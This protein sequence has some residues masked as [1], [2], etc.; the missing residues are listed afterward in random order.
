MGTDKPGFR[1]GFGSV[2][3]AAGFLFRAHRLWPISLVPGAI[4]FALVTAFALL[5][6]LLLRPA[7]TTWLNPEGGPYAALGAGLAGWLVAILAGALGALLALAITPP[8]SAP[9]LEHIVSARERS[10]GVPDRQ[11]IG[12]FAEMAFGLK[13]QLFAAGFA[14]PTLA[15]LWAIDLLFPPAAIVTVPL[16]LVV[17][18]AALSWNLLDY[19][20]TLRGVR[21]RDRLRLMAA[22]KAAILGFGLAFAALFWLPCFQVL[23]LPVGVAAAA[24]LMWT[25]LARDPQLL[26]GL[27][28]TSGDSAQVDRDAKLAP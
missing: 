11:P 19:P 8:L 28:R 3:R 2:F 22:H 16:K 25:I 20:L 18:S 5:A 15:V 24:E 7:V 9:A 27:A 14:V 10:L 1:V 12:L 26:P 13:A 21:L 23:M 6:V 17:V 4:L